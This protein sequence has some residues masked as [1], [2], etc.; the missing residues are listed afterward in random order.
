MLILGLSIGLGAFPAYGFTPITESVVGALHAGFLPDLAIAVPMAAVFSRTL[1][2]SLV[3]NLDRD[4]VTVAKSFGHS[5]RFI[6]LHHVFRNSLIPFIVVIGLQVRYLLGGVV[7]IERIFGINGVGSL[8]VEAAFA[9][10][11][12]V[13]QTCAVLFLAIVLAVN[14]VV[15]TICV[16]LAPSARGSKPIKVS[17]LLENKTALAG[18]IITLVFLLTI[19]VGP[20]VSPWTAVGS[21]FTKVLKSPSWSHPFGTDSLGRDVVTGVMEGARVSLA[22]SAS[23]VLL[24][25]MSGVI[26]GLYAGYKGGAGLT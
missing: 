15:D 5:P 1:R 10:D 11:Y 7:I 8:M 22:I 25:M 23:G 9:R 17:A 21:D 13:V 16:L 26:T 14:F 12:F 20:L 4:H 3:E 24:A 6:F 2:A 19:I 18:S